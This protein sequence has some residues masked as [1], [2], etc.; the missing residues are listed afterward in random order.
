MPSVV[1]TGIAAITGLA[2]TSTGVVIASNLLLYA[3]VSAASLLLQQSMLPNQKQEIGTKLSA[4]LGGAVNQ[5]IHFGRKETAGSFLYINTWGISGRVPNAFL[6]RVYC[7]GDRP[8]SGFE[9]YIWA[10]GRKCS[11]DPAVTKTLGGVNLGHPITAF[12][13]TGGQR[14]WV[15]F[16]DGSQNSADGYLTT[17]FGSDPNRPWTSDF[18]GRGRPY[19]IVTQKYDKKQ[20]IGQVDVIA[21]VKNAKYYDWRNDGTNGGSGS[22][23]YGNYST[24]AEDPGNPVVTIYNIMRGVYYGNSWLYGG[25]SWPATR[26]D[27]DSWTAAANKCDE[28][29]DV[30]GGG[31]IKRYRMGAEIDLSEEPWTV[32]ERCLKACNGRLV[33]SGGVYKIYVGGIGASVFSF[34]DDDIIVA[35]QE[36][37]GRLFPNREE[38]AN[39]V[40]GTY[41]EPDSGGEAKAF[42]ARFNQDYIDAD[43]DVRKTAID[44]EYCRDNRQAQRLA[45]LALNDNR[46]FR[47]FVVAFWTQARKLEPCDVV[48]WTSTRFGFENKKFIVGDVTL[49]DDGIVILNLREADATDADWDTSYEDP[50]E[51]GYF[52]DIDPAPQTISTTVTAVSINDDDGNGRR[53]AIRV[54]SDVWDDTNSPAEIMQ[55]CQALLWRV[56]K[57]AGTPRIFARG[58]ID[59]F[60][61]PDSADVGDAIFTDNSFMPNRQVQVSFKIKPESD[62]ETTWGSW[63]TITLTPARL[64]SA[65]LADGAVENST[66]GP[67]AV[68]TPKIKPKSVESRLGWKNKGNSKTFNNVNK[69]GPVN[70]A[71]PVGMGKSSR[72]SNP[73]PSAVYLRVSFSADAEVTDFRAKTI[74]DVVS[75]KINVGVYS[76]PVDDD[77]DMLKSKAVLLFSKSVAGSMSIKKDG[78]VGKPGSLN[79]NKAIAMDIYNGKSGNAQ[80]RQYYAQAKY[81]FEVA[82]D[83]S[84]ISAKGSVSDFRVEGSYS[85]R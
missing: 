81:S 17:K 21:V 49:K 32:I 67:D 85:K 47:T 58:R 9:D 12:N 38:I 77:G 15:K 55:D 40:T 75:L 50:Y 31:T 59:G 46:R 3:G 45:R 14:L 82:G 84:D 27:N 23:R 64:R 79:V 44:F 30:A 20:P 42:K 48:S 19:M 61:D 83:P 71:A 34:T 37:T 5:A 2:A 56:R 62:R 69:I 52:E 72:I 28:N 35:P 78:H 39:T 16:Y 51:T 6:T 7:L 43:G 1:A 4:V 26:F 73:N 76:A 22:Q 25:Q 63:T 11:Y 10:G 33:E 29:V 57:S 41:T 70:R 68:D 66:L 24:Y 80:R 65:D 54:E 13:S 36:L 74:H 60:F 53:P 18:V 8:V